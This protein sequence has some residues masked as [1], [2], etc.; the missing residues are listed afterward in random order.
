MPGQLD[1]Y[2]PSKTVPEAAAASPAVQRLA[3]R[4]PPG[5]FLGTS[6]W[7]FPG[8]KGLVWRGEHSEQVLARDGLVAYAAHPLLRAVGVD[9]TFYGPVTDDVLAAYASAV[10]DGFRFLV[11]ASEALTWARFPHHPRYGNRK[12]LENPDF[13]SPGYALDQVVQPFVDGLGDKAG[14][15]L[16][17]VPPQRAEDLGGPQRFADRLHRFLGA[18]PRGPTYAVELRTDE[19]LSR[20]LADALL[21]V[22][23]LPCLNAIR[24]MPDVLEQAERVGLDRFEQLLLR[25]MLTRELDYEAARAR[26]HPFDRLRSP[27]PRTR[28]QVAT[29]IEGFIA[30]D[31]K[32]LVIINNKAEGSAPLSVLRLTERIAEGRPAPPGRA[33]AP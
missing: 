22:G 17:Q 23:A 2:G 1:L 16:F 10:P 29:L 13:L 11:K 6:S 14:A 5:L 30:R 9:R 31:K 18:L 4:L 27:D 28:D 8:W 12:G 3:A 26:F 19:L 24:G 15:L 20:A 25:W 32:A 33:E 7:S 21:D